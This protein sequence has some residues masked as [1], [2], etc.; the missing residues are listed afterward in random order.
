MASLDDRSSSGL[1]HALVDVV[2]DRVSDKRRAGE[3]I[4]ARV[5]AQRLQSALREGVECR[6]RDDVE[7]LAAATPL[8]ERPQQRLQMQQPDRAERSCAAGRE[9]GA[10]RVLPPPSYLRGRIRLDRGADRVHGPVDDVLDR[11]GARDLLDEKWPDGR[12][13]NLDRAQGVAVLGPRDDDMRD[14]RFPGGR[15]GEP[16]QRGA[17][18]RLETQQ[19]FHLVEDHDHLPV[20]RD[21]CNDVRDVLA[22]GFELIVGKADHEPVE[23]LGELVWRPVASAQG[24]VAEP[25]RPGGHL[26][27]E[28]AS[29]PER[30]LS[31]G[32]NERRLADPARGG[33]L[34]D[35]V[36][37][38]AIAQFAVFRSRPTRSSSSRSGRAPLNL[39]SGC[40]SRLLSLAFSRRVKCIA[41]GLEEFR[42][43]GLL[44]RVGVAGFSV[45]GRD[46][47]QIVTQRLDAQGDQEAD[48]G[49]P[50]RRSIATWPSAGH[51]CQADLA[52]KSRRTR[53]SQSGKLSPRNTQLF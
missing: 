39:I 13:P 42:H 7:L 20:A 40:A 51:D 44:A 36:G 43:P 19:L 38:T 26:R 41:N 21:A 22:V 10:P 14:P 34:D 49:Q 29:S 27:D 6:D 23:H 15:S 11:G 31:T 50:K 9:G 52:L 45:I 12:T 8:L 25:I 37:L 33:D 47:A 32:L 1:G 18:C 35:V 48:L 24:G 53:G 46:V 2:E 28:E 5:R 17:R 30:D 3:G 16:Q 4:V